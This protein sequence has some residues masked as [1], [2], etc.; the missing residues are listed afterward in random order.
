MGSFLVFFT[1]EFSILILYNVQSGA[2]CVQLIILE[3]LSRRVNEFEIFNISE[4]SNSALIKDNILAIILSLIC[5]IHN[6]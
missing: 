2:D 4:S 5:Q 6:M 3:S 1:E